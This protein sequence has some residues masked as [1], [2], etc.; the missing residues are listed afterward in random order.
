MQHNTCSND[1]A[2]QQQA[3][4]HVRQPSLH[5][6]LQERPILKLRQGCGGAAEHICTTLA[7]F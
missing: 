4:T 3:E 6:S 7:C 1:A 2:L 5:E